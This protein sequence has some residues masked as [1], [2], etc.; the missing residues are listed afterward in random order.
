MQD[1]AKVVCIEKYNTRINNNTRVNFV[2]CVLTNVNLF[3]PISTLLPI[4]TS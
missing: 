4:H 2:F 1:G 3:L